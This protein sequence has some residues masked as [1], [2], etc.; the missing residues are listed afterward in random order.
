MN[1]TGLHCQTGGVRHRLFSL[2]ATVSSRRER[3]KS[4]VGD[5]SGLCH[6]TEGDGTGRE[7]PKKPLQE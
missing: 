7:S 2:R 6:G 4:T 3:Q 5:K 1:G